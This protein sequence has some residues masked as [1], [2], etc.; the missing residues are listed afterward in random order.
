MIDIARFKRQ[1]N[2]ENFGEEKQEILQ[3]AKVFIGGVGGVG[4]TAALYLVCAGIR[5][6]TL[7]HYGDLELP[8]L[9]RQILMSYE[10]VGYP[11]VDIAKDFLKKFDSDLKINTYN[12]RISES[13][14]DKMLDGCNLAI[15]ARPNFYERLAIAKG[16]LKNKI[17]MIDGAM[18]DM[19][20]H[21]FTMIPGET[22]CYGCLFDS[23][24]EKWKELEFPVLGAF[25]GLIGTILAIE[26]IKLLTNWH[27]PLY[28]EFLTID[29]INYEINRMKIKKNEKCILCGVSIDA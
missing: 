7:C 24:P 25:S 15:S 2:L 3:K 4:G 26:T 14:I 23:F 5:E 12:E 9:N 8:D 20:G 6:L 28:G 13:N 22:A 29:G 19:Y 10:K 27:K 11:R 1:L 18:Y 21:V 16:C 17:P